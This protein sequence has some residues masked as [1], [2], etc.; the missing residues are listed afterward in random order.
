MDK[1]KL[2]ADLDALKAGWV[3]TGVDGYDRLEMPD[4]RGLIIRSKDEDGQFIYSIRDKYVEVDGEEKRSGRYVEIFN[5]ADSSA[6]TEIDGLPDW[7][8][9][10]VEAFVAAQ[11][12]EEAAPEI[13][14][15]ETTP[16]AEEDIVS[17]NT[18]EPVQ[19]PEALPAFLESLEFQQRDPQ[20]QGGYFDAIISDAYQIAQLNDQYILHDGQNNH[21]AVYS[22]EKG[23]NILDEHVF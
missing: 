23:L 1:E 22:A 12:V 17:L 3:E 10:G 19:Y 4:G 15:Q 2:Q 9:N 18:N 7:V 13:V 20:S 8:I 21:I 14:E 6:S 5:T 11:P 16:L